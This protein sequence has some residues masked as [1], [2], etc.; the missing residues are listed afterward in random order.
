MKLIAI[1][2]T[3]VLLLAGCS[4][5]QADPA[6]C[7]TALGTSS[8]GPAVWATDKSSRPAECKGLSEEQFG[9]VST[10]VQEEFQKKLSGS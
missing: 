9:K 3:L 2:T 8:T 5:D 10:E 1:A 7:K 4:S 6:A